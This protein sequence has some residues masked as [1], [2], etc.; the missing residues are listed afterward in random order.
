MTAPV[1]V[2]NSVKVAAYDGVG[3]NVA[4]TPN[5]EITLTVQFKEDAK[6]AQAPPHPT[7]VVDAEGLAV[8]VTIDPLA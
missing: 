4:V 5:A 7:N 2:P 8:N 3:L 1:P 6:L